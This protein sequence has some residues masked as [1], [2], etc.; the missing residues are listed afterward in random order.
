VELS[1]QV[2]CVAC[3]SRTSAQFFPI[4]GNFFTEEE[5]HV[6]A[7]K[8]SFVWRL[9][10]FGTRSSVQ[11]GSTHRKAETETQ[12]GRLTLEHLCLRHPPRPLLPQSLRKTRKPQNKTSGKANQEESNT[13]AR[14]TPKD[15]QFTA[16]KASF[17]VEA[18]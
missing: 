5:R 12:T 6:L 14:K 4:T 16:R 7:H 15:P 2:S 3:S 9:L 11:P 18:S 10:S 13:G 17:H 1:L 8:L